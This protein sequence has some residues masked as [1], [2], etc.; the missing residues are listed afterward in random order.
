MALFPLLSPLFPLAS[1]SQEAEGGRG[2]KQCPRV[3]KYS[4][5]S[6]ILLLCSHS[7]LTLDLLSG[8]TLDEQT[9]LMV[10]EPP[11]V[12]KM[13]LESDTAPLPSSHW[14]SFLKLSSVTQ[15]DWL[16]LDCLVCFLSPHFILSPLQPGLVG[17]EQS[18]WD[19]K[20]LNVLSSPSP[21]SFQRVQ[22]PYIP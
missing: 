12:S 14:V 11:G 17:R 6:Q 16:T 1:S 3:M 5:P 15:R 8:P 18:R 20:P 7:D 2:T 13:T 22:I 19:L 4:S 9:P 10:P 21:Q